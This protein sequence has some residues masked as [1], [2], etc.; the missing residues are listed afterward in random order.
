LPAIVG[1]EVNAEHHKAGDWLT[2]VSSGLSLALHAMIVAGLPPA[3]PFLP[4]Y[5]RIQRAVNTEAARSAEPNR[6]AG[7]FAI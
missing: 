4:C 1:R 7:G 6:A 5:R 3:R 2:R